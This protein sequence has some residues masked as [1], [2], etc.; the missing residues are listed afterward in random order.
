MATMNLRHI[1]AW[2]ARYVCI[3]EV[4][5]NYCNVYGGVANG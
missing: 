2:G 3:A 5:G 1:K 4:N